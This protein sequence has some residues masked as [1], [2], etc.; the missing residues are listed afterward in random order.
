MLCD[1]WDIY[2]N[3]L[4]FKEHHFEFWKVNVYY[5]VL[6]KFN[7]LFNHFITEN[8]P[9]NGMKYLSIKYYNPKSGV[10]QNSKSDFKAYFNTDGAYTEGIEKM[11]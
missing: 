1:S 10:L 5:S 8:I 6:E 3:K 2:I 7:I 9:A 11:N 4:N